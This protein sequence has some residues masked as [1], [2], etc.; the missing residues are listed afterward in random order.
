MQYFKNAGIKMRQIDPDSGKEIELDSLN[1][2]EL[3]EEIRQSQSAVDGDDKKKSKQPEVTISKS[4]RRRVPVQQNIQDDD[5]YDEESDE[6]FGSADGGEESQ[7]QAS[8][9]EDAEEDMEDEI[10]DDDIDKN[11]LAALKGNAVLDKKDRK[12]K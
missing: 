12:K 8:G 7:D 11:E 2:D 9:D 10:D 5:D 6:S 3:D 4:G 1:S